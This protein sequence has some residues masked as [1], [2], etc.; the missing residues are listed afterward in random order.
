MRMR[1]SRVPCAHAVRARYHYSIFIPTPPTYLQNLEGG[2]HSSLVT[3]ASGYGCSKDS[4]VC[5]FRDLGIN[6]YSD[7]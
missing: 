1:V 6:F 4:V 2:A 3:I 7:W 5:G